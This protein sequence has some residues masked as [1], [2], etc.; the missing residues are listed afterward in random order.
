M[1]LPSF[2]DMGAIFRANQ[3]NMDVFVAANRVA[4]ET[5]QAYVKRHMEIVQSGLAKLTELMQTF[6]ESGEPK[7]K[8]AKQLGL[9]KE[10]REGTIASMEELGAL[11]QKSNQEVVRLLSERF[12]QAI[13]ELEGVIAKTEHRAP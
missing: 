13:E 7:A 9:L 12:T 5:S 3:R 10:A 6:A 1:K 11:I 2:G 4:F 8:L